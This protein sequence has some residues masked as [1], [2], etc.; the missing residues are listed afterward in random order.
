M[1]LNRLGPLALV[2]LLLVTAGCL[3]T[4]SSDGTATESPATP[5][6]TSTPEPESCDESERATVDPFREEVTPSD[7][8]EPPAEWTESSVREYVV[9]YEEAYARNQRLGD[10]ST[11]VSVIVG[12]VSAERVDDGWV[13]RLTS[14]TNTWAQGS[15]DGSETATVVHGDGAPIPVAYRVTDDRVVRAEA[16]YGTTPEPAGG[17]TVECL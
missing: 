15:P 1:S 16:D 6:G 4:L 9:A 14:R 2:A 5:T 12:D 17:R 7:H 13:V 8:P 3:G 10:E 11:Q